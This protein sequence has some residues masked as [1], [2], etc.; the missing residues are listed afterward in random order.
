MLFNKVSS[1]L[2]NNNKLLK[3]QIQAQRGAA[4]PDQ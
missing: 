2:F 4:Q 3:K 1:Q